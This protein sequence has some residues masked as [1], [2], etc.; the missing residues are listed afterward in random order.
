MSMDRLLQLIDCDQYLISTNGNHFAH[1]DREAVARVIKYG[2]A[3]PQLY[4][5]FRTEFNEVWARED[6]QE[7]YGYSTV[8]PNPDDSWLVGKKKA[9]EGLKVAL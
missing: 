3:N 6:L 5:N 2:G 7:K 8:Y 4:F 1:P 9:L